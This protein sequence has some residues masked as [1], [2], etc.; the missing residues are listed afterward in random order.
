MKAPSC[1]RTSRAGGSLPGFSVLIIAFYIHQLESAPFNVIGPSQPIMA[2]AGEDAVLPCHLSP[3]MSAEDM[4]VRWF[5]SEF[6]ALLHLYHNGQDQTENQMPEYRGRTEFLRDGIANGSVAL[7]IRDIRPSDEGQYSC[8]FQSITYFK[9]ALVEVKVTGLG[10]TPLISVEGYQDGGIRMVCQSAGWY[11]EPEVLWRDPSGKHL[12]SLSEAK[13]QGANGLFDVEYSIILQENTN[14]NLFCWIR[15]PRLN[16]AKESTV[17]IS[18][19]FYPRVDPWKVALVTFL[20]ILLILLILAAYL[21]RAKGKLE[22]K[23]QGL[24]AE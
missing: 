11:P 15:N 17:Y 10:S 9:H 13:P 6:S 3:T 24:A 12:P 5:R 21:Y 18:E 8:F 14:Q 22:K 19:S 7:R 16:Q 23:L 2:I 20:V 1:S 4:E